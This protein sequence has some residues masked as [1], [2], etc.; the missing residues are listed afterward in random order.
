M[1][2]E[3]GFTIVEVIIAVFL[4]TIG[5]AGL[6]GTGALLT[7]MIA[8]GQRSAVAALFA[9]QRMEQLRSTACTAQVA[10]ADTLIRGGAWAAINTWTFVNSGNS[11][12][13]ISLTSTYKTAPNKTRVDKSETEVSC[14]F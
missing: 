6:V 9:G 7:R 2:Q 10:G 12:W 8:R 14:L 4:L 1:K 3:R 11:T 5:L 13:R